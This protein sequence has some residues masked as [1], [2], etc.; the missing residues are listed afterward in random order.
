[1]SSK[2]ARN[3]NQQAPF[4]GEVPDF[5]SLVGSGANHHDHEQFV[6]PNI[7]TE[8]GSYHF[9]LFTHEAML[10]GIRMCVPHGFPTK[11]VIDSLHHTHNELCQE[12]IGK[13]PSCPLTA[14]GCHSEMFRLEVLPDEDYSRVQVVVGNRLVR[15]DLGYV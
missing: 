7:E 10:T 14:C 8:W 9:H 12:I 13:E 3:K 4:N 2:R 6:S 5:G 11:F 1:M 15:A